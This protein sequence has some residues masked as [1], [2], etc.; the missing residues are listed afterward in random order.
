MD[1]C[2]S[3]EDFDRFRAQGTVEMK[4]GE[5]GLAQNGSGPFKLSINIRYALSTHAAEGSTVR[6]DYESRFG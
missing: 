1:S 3:T 6:I 5:Y 2:L 4:G